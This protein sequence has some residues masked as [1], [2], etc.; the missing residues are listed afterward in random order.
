METKRLGN[1]DMNIT[2]IG[3][4]TWAI[5]GTWRWGWG[6]QDDSNSIATIREAID[7]GINWIDTAAVYGLGHSEEIVGKALREMKDK[8]YVFTKGTKIWD[9][10][11]NVSESMKAES[12]RKEVEASL[13]RLGVEVIDLYQIHW[14]IPDEQ[15]EEGWETLAK[16]KD[17]G[18]IRYIGVSNFSVSQ[19][20]RAEKI[21][22]VTSLQP[23]YNLIRQD[24]AKEILPYCEQQNIGVI[25]Y[26]PMASGLLSGKM[27]RER[28]AA[29]DPGDWRK[30]NPDFTEPRV[31]RNLALQQLLKEIGAQYGATAG[32]AA[33]AWTLK[34]P[35]VTGAIV[36]M[37][38]P[39]QIEGIIRAGELK[40]SDADVQRME[41]FLNSR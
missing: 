3:L 25:V 12:L 34:N 35:A 41:S 27:S 26:S 21:A 24:V 37:R 32:E 29:M 16:L 39:D 7:H 18:K 36:G 2:R 38:K 5:G 23:P 30:T 40:L 33:I 11:G 31:T 9:S 6:E 13:V 17:E 1:S 10:A 14:P 15:I 19:L 28:I 8:P 22:P 20:R 4:G